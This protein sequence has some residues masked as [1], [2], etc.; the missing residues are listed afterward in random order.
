MDTIK[1]LNNFMLPHLH[2]QNIREGMG[3]IFD[4]TEQFNNLHN[5]ICVLNTKIEFITREN[6]IYKTQKKEMLDVYVKIDTEIKKLNNTNIVNFLQLT[7]Y[8][9]EE[10]KNKTKPTI[11]SVP[12]QS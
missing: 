8:E 9:L 7:K 10:Q 12:Q 5:E 11:V 6:D 3:L 1:E 4:L 2:Q